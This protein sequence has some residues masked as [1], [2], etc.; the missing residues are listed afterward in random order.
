MIVVYIIVCVQTFTYPGCYIYANHTFDCELKYSRFK[1]YRL[2]R[3]IS[4]QLSDFQY[5][6]D[7]NFAGDVDTRRSTT[8]YIFKISGEPVSW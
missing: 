6:V 7:A 2:C 1:V 3:G 8:G 5:Y 4:P